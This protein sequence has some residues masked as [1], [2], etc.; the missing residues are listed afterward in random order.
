MAVDNLVSQPLGDEVSSDLLHSLRGRTIA[1]NATWNI[2]GQGLPLLV[3]AV[4]I[5]ILIKRL[6]VDRFGVLTL[7]W[8]LV[9]Y[10]GFFDM[11]LGRALTK[12][13]SESLAAKREKETASAIWTA[14][15]ILLAVGAVFAVA[16]FLT[17]HWLIYAVIKIPPRL[18][19]ETVRA[20]RWLAISI[21]MITVTA[22][23]RGVLEAQHRFGLVNIVRVVMG[24]FSYVGP[25]VA[26]VFSP[27]LALLCAVL[28]SG[29]I[30]AAL[31]HLVLCLQ[32][33]P[34][35]RNEVSVKRS[36]L[37]RLVSVGAW[38]TVSN[39]VAPV[40]TYVERF[41]IG[42]LLPVAAIAYYATPGEVVTRFLMIPAAITTVLF[43]TFA[44]LSVLDSNRLKLNYER[45]IRFC[46]MLV[47]P[48]LFLIFLFAP[49]GLHLWL[50]PVFAQNSAALL[51][52]M[53]VGILVNSI[54]QIPYALLQ[55]ANRPDLP[56]KLHLA[57]A[58]IY[59]AALVVGIRLGGITGAAAVW[60]LRLILEG[61]LLL[62]FVHRTLVPASLRTPF[63]LGC[64][65]TAAMLVSLFLSNIW[66]KA[67][68][69]AAV[70]VGGSLVFWRFILLREERQEIIGLLA[71]AN[72]FKKLESGKIPF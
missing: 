57:E 31:V 22:G 65:A 27:D 28:V 4:I 16:L 24:V 14:I 37:P 23:L 33:L 20:V 26:A 13:V 38:I 66:T 17:S 39:T 34:S 61:L 68:W 46:F 58:P 72:R 35:L 70:L 10:F 30:L 52:W 71:T 47:F 69:C 55:A 9:G 12:I 54:A 45:G 19:Q 18:Q 32:T 25:L 62:F 5:P 2:L 67:G 48:G 53:T 11:G 21:P 36:V 15:A 51:R 60:A 1:R 41:M 29:R 7:A 6:G 43:P 8:A 63:V 44:A 59:L 3:A 56:G 49:E 64:S 40:L 50:G 42:F